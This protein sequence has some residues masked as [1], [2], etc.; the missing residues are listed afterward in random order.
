MSNLKSNE[1][2]VL[3]NVIFQKELIVGTETNNPSNNEIR[4]CIHFLVEDMKFNGCEYTAMQWE[5]LDD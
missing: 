3:V 2:K 5:E 1:R 4:E